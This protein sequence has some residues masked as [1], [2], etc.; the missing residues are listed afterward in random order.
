MESVWEKMLENIVEAVGFS[1]TLAHL[2][3]N[4]DLLFYSCM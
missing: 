4:M 3:H 2:F 1:E